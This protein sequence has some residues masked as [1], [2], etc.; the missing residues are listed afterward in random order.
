M[1]IHRVLIIIIANF[2]IAIRAQAPGQAADFN[3]DNATA[4]SY[5]CDMICQEILAF[6]IQSDLE[7]IGTNFDFDFYNTA[8]NFPGSAPGD[9]LKLQAINTSTIT[10]LLTGMSSYR[11]QYT[12]KDLD[13]NPA[14]STGFIAIPF[15][16]PA[17]DGRFPLI[18]FAH[19]T[20]GVYR[21]CAPSSAPELFDYDTWTPLLLRGYAVVATDYVGLGNNF[22]AHKYVSFAAHA[23]DLYY[24][25]QAARQA[26]P[27][28]FT[29]E[30]MSMGHS[31]GGGAVWKL[32]EYPLVQSPSSGYLGTVAL[33]PAAKLYDMA[34]LVAKEILPLPNFHDY[35]FTGEIA[36]LAVAVR[37]VFP[38]YNS[39][40]LGDAMKKRIELSDIGQFCSDAFLG[41]S[42]DLSLDELVAVDADVASDETL[43]QFQVL[44]APAQGSCASQPML[45]IQGLNDTSILPASTAAA[46]KDATGFGNEI[47]MVWYPGLD[48]SAV[49]AAAV[50]EWLKFI[51]DRF[52]GRIADGFSTNRTVKPFDLVNAYAPLDL[53]LPLPFGL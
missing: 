9:L 37:R 4:V 23:H 11:F 45:I 8:D 35:V 1:A 51:D 36:S 21:G 31:Q 6:S 41:L 46:F 20:I 22:T 27:I 19:G 16:R 17:H 24:S 12:S 26:F 30:W 48:H 29:D 13:G 28:A 39:P 5:G 2:A 42:L 10:G 18:A 15:T 7:S 49:V 34:I 53:P 50:P 25:V 44:N 43:H 38:Q 32:S 3:V 33:A 52:T 47:H 40:W 14:P